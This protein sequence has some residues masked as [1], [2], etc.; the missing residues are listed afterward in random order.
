MLCGELL[1][2]DQEYKVIRE[3]SAKISLYKDFNHWEDQMMHFVDINF[4]FKPLQCLLSG[5][6]NK[7]NMVSGTK[8]QNDFII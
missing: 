5:H 7:S 3:C 4:F 8:M 2:I 1:R 6:M